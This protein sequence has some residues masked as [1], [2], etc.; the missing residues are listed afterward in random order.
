MYLISVIFS[1]CVF[2]ILFYNKNI[3]KNVY[4]EWPHILGGIGLLWLNSLY[5][6]RSEVARGYW[7]CRTNESSHSAPW[8]MSQIWRSRG[9]KRIENKVSWIWYGKRELHTLKKLFHFLLLT[10]QKKM[11]A[12]T[13]HHFLPTPLASCLRPTN[14]IV[15]EHLLLS[16]PTP[17]I[18]YVQKQNPKIYTSST[19]LYWR[20]S[21]PS[22][23]SSQARIQEIPPLDFTLPHILKAAGD[24]PLI[25]PPSCHPLDHCLL[26]HHPQRGSDFSLS[27]YWY[28]MHTSI[29]ALITLYFSNFV[30][31]PISFCMMENFLRQEQFIHLSVSGIYQNA[32]RV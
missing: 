16:K 4:L 12:S 9:P 22:T 14:P 8:K 5:W 1:I 13:L 11:M 28:S 26:K 17:Q 30:N 18:Q 27:V 7:L 6:N 3:D 20:I 2:T 31:I 24:R 23:I 19:S 15:L 10:Y 21:A 25:F 29:A 32:G